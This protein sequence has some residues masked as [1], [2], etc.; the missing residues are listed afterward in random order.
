MLGIVEATPF[1][2]AAGNIGLNLILLDIKKQPIELSVLLVDI[3]AVGI[4]L[5]LFIVPS[6]ARNKLIEKI[7]C[8]KPDENRLG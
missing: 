5:I 1:F 7:F 4:S 6:A 8:I 2:L 3:I